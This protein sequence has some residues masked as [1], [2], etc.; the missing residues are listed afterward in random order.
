[1]SDR[2]SGFTAVMAGRQPSEDRLDYFPTPPWAARAGGE[3][4]R[5]LDPEAR[6]CWEPAAG[7][8][9]MV[10]G[11]R[12][13]FEDVVGSDIV[14]RGGG[15]PV[16]DFLDPRS[17]VAPGADWIVTN[18]P[19][20]LAEAFARTA[21][22]QARR[23]V[24]LLCRLQFLESALRHDLFYGSLR[25]GVVAPFAE[26]V[27]MVKGRYDPAA[28]TATAYAWFIWSKRHPAGA[29]IIMPLGPGARA[30]LTRPDDAR[31]FGV[32]TDTPLFA[33]G[34]E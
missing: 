24:A 6:T 5:R 32:A 34:G 21:F 33:E 25:L 10:H 22:A 17:P 31:R 12:D 13:Y 30:R 15:F 19:F 29:P 18:P 4:I 26:R 14:D 3:L 16:Q 9:H 27:A 2:P 23:G 1:M 28:S 7:E 8:G 11:L 20:S